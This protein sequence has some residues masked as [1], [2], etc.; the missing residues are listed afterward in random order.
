MAT[1]KVLEYTDIGTGSDHTASSWIFSKDKDRQIIID[2]SLRDEE[3]VKQWSSQLPKLQEDLLEGEELG[4]AFYS[5]LDELYG[6]VQIHVGKTTSPWYTMG[7]VTQRLQ[8]VPLTD[9][10]GEKDDKQ[11]DEIAEWSDSTKLAWSTG[12]IHPEDETVLKPDT[13]KYFANKY[14]DLNK[15]PEVE[16]AD[17]EEIEDMN[18]NGK[19]DKEEVEDLLKP[20]AKPTPSPE[21][22][23]DPDVEEGDPLPEKTITVVPPMV[24]L[25][26]GPAIVDIT[27]TGETPKGFNL[28]QVGLEDK[29]KVTIT[30]VNDTSATGEVKLLDGVTEILPEDSKFTIQ[31]GGG[32]IVSNE[33]LVSNKEIEPQPPEP[34]TPP[35]EETTKP[36]TRVKVVKFNAN[37]GTGTMEDVPVELPEQGTSKYLLP[38]STFTPPENKEFKTWAE[39]TEGTKVR[40]ANEEIEFGLPGEFILYAIWQ[41]ASPKE[42]KTE[43]KTEQEQPK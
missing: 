18:N 10:T 5:D 24:N 29:V 42:E 14:P 25:S 12:V 15:D 36:A 23:K 17:K 41:D 8:R 13:D 33:V 39:D 19:D 40:N 34:T 38:T 37:G 9:S 20:P 1:L 3:N 32:S 35:K 7:P 21:T 43:N 30:I 11:K 4:K 6:H 31:S 16:D 27:T 2:Q 28:K 22:G 26:T